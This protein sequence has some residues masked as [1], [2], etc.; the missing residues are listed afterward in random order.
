M[1]LCEIIVP[2]EISILE[3]F[4]C[5]ID[6]ADGQL[7]SKVVEKLIFWALKTKWNNLCPN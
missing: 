6:T 1:I 7:A 2:M 4:Y 3:K 5:F